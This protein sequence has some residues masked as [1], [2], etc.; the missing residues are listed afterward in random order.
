MDNKI[1]KQRLFD[2]FSYEWIAIIIVAVVA[3]I[4]WELV[5]TIGAV[6]L[7]PGQQFKYYYDY[8]IDSS[9]TSSLMNILIKDGD[10]NSVF[11]YDV[12]EFK[13]EAL[14]KDFPQ[15]L[16]ARVGI[17]EGDFI[18]TDCID[19]TK[20]EGA[21]ENT[22]KTIRLK[23]LVDTYKGYAYT[24]LYKDAVKYLE[25]FLPDGVAFNGEISFDKL[26]KDKIEQVFRQRMAK[27]NRFRAEEQIVNGIAL[28]EKRI[29]KLCKEVVDF[30]KLLSLAEEY[31]ELFYNYTKY[32]Q[33]HAL[34]TDQ[35][36]KEQ[37]K[38]AIELEKEKGRENA[39]YALCVSALKGGQGK[40]DP[41]TYFKI[42]GKS[43]ADGVAIMV[44]DF[45]NEQPHLQYEV[46]SA[47]NQ[48]V[49]QCSTLLDN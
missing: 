3:M 28:E 38:G 25:S 44:F 36:L 2:F 9:S 23:Q 6:R 40:T 19:Y 37:Y 42:A 47:I 48:I 15:V 4:F 27:D 13:T 17:Q 32:E 35:K 24:E 43:T 22:E 30:G 34:T 5:Y 10:G 18:I 26:S 33:S 8:S 20:Q 29:E 46:I 14:N 16:E 31:P 39:P 45:H 11:S 12:L 1:T 49:R 41:T 21:D 7:T